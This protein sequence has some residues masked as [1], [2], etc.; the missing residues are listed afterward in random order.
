MVIGQLNVPNI[1]LFKAKNDPPVGAYGHGAEASQITF[2]LVQ[3]I[4]GQ[5]KSSGNAGV[6]EHGQN[7]LYSINYIG[8]N[9]AAVG[10]LLQ[11]LWAAML[12][13]AYH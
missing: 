3:P 5:I 6:I 1:T 2:K 7:S 4:A 10:F 12:E 11:A 13:A 9:A 8:A